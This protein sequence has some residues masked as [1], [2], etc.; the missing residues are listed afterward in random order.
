MER[1]I[2]EV[3]SGPEVVRY[4]SPFDGQSNYPV[5]FCIARVDDRQQQGADY[6]VPSGADNGFL[7]THGFYS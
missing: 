7:V 1:S 4:S 5:R 3:D 6:M 2:P